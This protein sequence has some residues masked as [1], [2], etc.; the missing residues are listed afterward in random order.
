MFSIFTNFIFKRLLHES[1]EERTNV[2]APLM[3]QA[4]E[5]AAVKDGVLD[6]TEFGFLEKMLSTVKSGLKSAAPATG[7]I[8]AAAQE[9]FRDLDTDGISGLSLDELRPHV[10][11]WLRSL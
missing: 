1:D 2:L 7:D 3:F 11:A 5:G 10:S 4:L 9:T 6:V 8:F